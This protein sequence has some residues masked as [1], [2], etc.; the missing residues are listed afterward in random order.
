MD[1]FW[2]WFGT[3]P[4]YAWVAIVAIGGGTATSITKLVVTHRER[5]AQIEHQSP[6]E[7]R[8]DYE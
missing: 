3:I 6:R 5:M 8:D 4:W 1:G 7:P 2:S